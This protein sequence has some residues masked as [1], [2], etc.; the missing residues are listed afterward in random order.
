[1]EHLRVVF[2][3]LRENELFVK[4]EKCS[5]AQQ[6]V[7][8]LGHIVEGGRIQI[9]ESK[10]WAIVEWEPPTNVTKLRSFLGL[11]NYYRRFIKSYSKIIAPLTD[12]LK[13]GKVWDWDP[14]CEKAF[15]QLKQVMIREPVLALPDYSKPYEA[16]WLVFLAEFDFM[17]EYKPESANTVA[18]ALSRKIEFLKYA[19]FI[20]ATKECPSEEADRL[21]LRHVVKYKGVPLSIIND[22]DG[23]FTG[24]F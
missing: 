21:F 18:N 17:M 7:Q 1:M 3:I 13:K 10:I 16:R 24:Q 2:Q 12:M 23:R 4:E 22:R 20:L 19:T 6:E 15:N 5:F 8:F 11:A 14:Q 9:D